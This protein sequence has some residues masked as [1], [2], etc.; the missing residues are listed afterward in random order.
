MEDSDAVFG[1]M[2][3]P[4]TIGAVSWGHPSIEHSARYIER[5]MRDEGRD[6]FT[7]WL[8]E[9]N[10]DQAPVGLAGFLTPRGSVL[11]LAYVVRADEWGHGYASEAVPAAMTLAREAGR[12][13]FAT[14][15]PANVGSI[16]VAEKAGLERRGAM[17][18]GTRGLMLV[19]RWSPEGV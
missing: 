17:I 12:G 8:L 9:R 7:M 11:E 15:R 4:Q 14:I 5:R 3:D 1:I 19:Y 13:V 6:G 2:G 18:I 10:E 16:R